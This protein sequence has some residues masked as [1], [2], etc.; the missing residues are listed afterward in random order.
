MICPTARLVS[1][2]TMAYKR[3]NGPDERC[4]RAPRQLACDDEMG[5]SDGSCR[6]SDPR[7]FGFDGH[8]IRNS[9]LNMAQTVYYAHTHTHTQAGLT[10][11]LYMNPHHA[12]LK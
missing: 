1:G 7:V 11:P 4:Y 12:V 9:L 8:A 2:A 10:R 3:R 5:G 6:V